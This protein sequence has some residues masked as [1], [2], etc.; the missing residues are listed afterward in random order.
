MYL[1]DLQKL[2]K[3]GKPSKNKKDYKIIPRLYN[4]KPFINLK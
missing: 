2:S 1:E 3:L 4:P